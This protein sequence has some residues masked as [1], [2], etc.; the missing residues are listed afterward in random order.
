MQAHREGIVRVR[1]L[2]DSR[3]DVFAG[4]G[5]SGPS[6]LRAVQPAVDAVKLWKFVPGR[7]AGRPVASCLDV[8]VYFLLRNLTAT[9]PLVMTQREI[10][11]GAPHVDEEPQTRTDADYPAELEARF[12][13]A[14]IA[15]Q[16]EVDDIGRVTSAK[17]IRCPDPAR[18]FPAALAPPP[19]P[20]PSPRR[21]RATCRSPPVHQSVIVLPGTADHPGHTPLLPLQALSPRPRDPGA[22]GWARGT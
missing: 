11:R 16:M 8:P 7:A 14:E 15:I 19:G 20:G 22:Q 9:G 12:P 3:G 13:G 18:S 21:S 4:P 10:P 6:D 5:P 2:V 17:V 1:V